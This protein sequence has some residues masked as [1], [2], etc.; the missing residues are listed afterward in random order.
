MNKTQLL[1][2]EGFIDVCISAL[3]A[4]LLPIPSRTPIHRRLLRL[5]AAPRRLSHS[6]IF[7]AWLCHAQAFELQGVAKVDGATV[8]GLWC[9]IAVLSTLDLTAP[10]A[11]PIV[12]RLEG[13]ASTLRFV[14]VRPFA[15]L[16]RSGDSRPVDGAL[17]ISPGQSAVEHAAIG[18]D[19][20]WA[21]FR[22]LRSCVWKAGRRRVC[23]A[24]L[25]PSSTVYAELTL[26]RAT[27]EFTQTMINSTLAAQLAVFSGAM[28]P[29]T[30]AL[31]PFFL[32][33]I[34]HLCISVSTDR[35][36]QSQALSKQ[37]C[38]SDTPWANAGCQQ[39]AVAPEL[40]PDEAAH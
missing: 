19:D 27:V 34:V 11:V 14:L 31:P 35:N 30:P 1:L 32:R 5:G 12:S 17:R 29:F 7:D 2:D 18:L 8:N 24:S 6:A 37:A 3:K 26:R 40:R 15:S 28:A 33:S 21:S 20:G 38:V 9:C 23:V 10:E 4:R 25:S 22:G 36:E 39:E 13:M 16:P